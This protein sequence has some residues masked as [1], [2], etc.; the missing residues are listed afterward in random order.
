MRL[1]FALLIAALLPAGALVPAAA[2][3]AVIGGPLLRDG[4]EI[5]PSLLTG[6]E[7]DRVPT[8]MSRG[9]DSIVLVADVHAAKDETHG[10]QRCSTHLRKTNVRRCTMLPRSSNESARPDH[11]S[12]H[13]LPITGDVLRF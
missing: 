8:S 9:P 4:L 6:V 7:L 10:L 11:R 1:T 3:A 13:R 5:V 2:Q 12:V